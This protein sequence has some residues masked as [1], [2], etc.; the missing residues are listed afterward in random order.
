[1]RFVYTQANKKQG[2]TVISGYFAADNKAEAT[3]LEEMAKSTEDG[4]ANEHLSSNG[5]TI[6]F[7]LIQSELLR[8]NIVRIKQMMGIQDI[9]YTLSKGFNG[10][11]ALLS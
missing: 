7:T 9:K 5:K 2:Q 6:A 8:M 11:K 10:D 1:M 4:K 3:L